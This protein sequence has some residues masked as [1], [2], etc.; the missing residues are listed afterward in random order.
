MIVRVLC[1]IQLLFQFFAVALQISLTHSR[2]LERDDLWKLPNAHSA[3][4][5]CSQL[6]DHLRHQNSLI[7]ALKAMLIRP[8]IFASMFKALGDLAPTVAPFV[9]KSLIEFV[10]ES[11]GP[12]PPNFELGLGLVFV[13]VALII[14][15]TLMRYHSMQL[16]SAQQVRLRA[17]LTA[18]IY[19]KAFNISPHSREQFDAAKIMTLISTDVNRMELFLLQLPQ[20]IISPCHLAII[21]GF[22]I[23]TIGAAAAFSGF[24]IIPV[25]RFFQFRF[26][27]IRVCVDLEQWK[28]P[29][30]NLM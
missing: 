30:T 29:L 8:I 3:Q 18:L 10:T 25:Q 14:F 12:T 11:Q 9:I 4:H 2:Q 5:N 16:F 17:A 7:Q 20:L 26:Q 27:K 21:L 15:Q 23:Y 6:E 1:V 28:L 24:A 13:F 19:K 22:L